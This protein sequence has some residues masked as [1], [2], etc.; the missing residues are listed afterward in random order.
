MPRARSA[1][2]EEQITNG[3]EPFQARAQPIGLD[4]NTRRTVGEDLVFV[5]H[6]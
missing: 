1:I 3:N 4:G 6:I 2:V 5:G